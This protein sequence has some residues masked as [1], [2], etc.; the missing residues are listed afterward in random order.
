MYVCLLVYDSIDAHAF[1]IDEQ[2]KDR[3]EDLH[4]SIVV[5]AQVEV[6]ASSQHLMYVGL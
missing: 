5:C 3:F 1:A 4:K 2:E 6:F